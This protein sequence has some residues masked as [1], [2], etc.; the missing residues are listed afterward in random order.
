MTWDEWRGSM[1]GRP[2]MWIKRLVKAFGCRIDL[3]KFIRADD[4]DCF[5]THPAYCVRIILWGGY[6]EEIWSGSENGAGFAGG[7]VYRTWFPGDIGL[8]RPEFCHRVQGLVKGPSY[9]LW[10]RGPTHHSIELRGAG[11]D[12]PRT[13][14]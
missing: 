14:P 7:G 2:A 6:V 5:H 3:H 10:L 13:T 11:W 8:V 12:N 9:S 1:D 4:D